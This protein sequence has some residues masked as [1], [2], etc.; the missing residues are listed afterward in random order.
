MTI[1]LPDNMESF[2]LARVSLG[3]YAS[4]DEAVADAVR[5]LMRDEAPS[6]E[7]DEPA[8]IEGNAGPPYKPIWEVIE[9]ENRTLPPEVWDDLP[10]DLSEQ[11]D[12]YIYGGPKRP[13]E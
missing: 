1:N 3:E 7:G 2:L 9:E 11:H 8:L 5:R 13:S 6:P 12:H 4:V 10:A